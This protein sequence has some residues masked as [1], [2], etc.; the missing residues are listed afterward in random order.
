MPHRS[1][2]RRLRSAGHACLAALALVLATAPAAAK[3]VDFAGYTWEV[4][5]GGGG[6]GP[7]HWSADNVRVA[8]DGLHLRIA[9]AAGQWSCAEVTMTRS[10][11]FGTFVFELAGRPDRFDRNIVLGLFDYPTADIG[12]DGTNEIDIEF[13]QWGDAGN[14]RRLNWTVYPPSLG[15]PPT[16]HEVPLALAGEASTHRFDWT[17]GGVKFASFDGWKDSGGLSPIAKWND[18][19]ARPRHHIPRQPLP[20][21]LNLWL[22]QGEAPVDGREVEVVIRSFS[23]TPH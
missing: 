15:P 22:F 4:R 5:E 14:D 20:V 1:P 7:N 17:S 16:H 12:P 13:A 6:P 10:L 21:H 11:G 18:A 2:G 3:T 9:A 23:F 19:P 8:A